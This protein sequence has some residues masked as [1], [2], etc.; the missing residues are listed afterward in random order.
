MNI[1]EFTLY[2]FSLDKLKSDVLALTTHHDNKREKLLTNCKCLR[3]T[4]LI[5]YNKIEE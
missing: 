1:L 5:N 3:M 2:I 4:T